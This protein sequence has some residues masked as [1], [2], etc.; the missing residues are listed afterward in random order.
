MGDTKC[1]THLSEPAKNEWKR[2][3]G[4]LASLDLL[5]GAD[6]AV[7]ALYCQ[8]WAR[9]V[10]AEKQVKDLGIVITAKNGTMMSNPYLSIANKAHEQCRRLVCELGLSPLARSK[11]KQKQVEAGISDFEL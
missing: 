2:I 3:T 9:W 5:T 10:E 11:M 1:P 8:S 7:I 6:R 4:E